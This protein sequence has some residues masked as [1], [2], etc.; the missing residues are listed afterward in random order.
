M[1][2]LPPEWMADNPRE[3]ARAT[4]DLHLPYVRTIRVRLKSDKASAKSGVVEQ[5]TT[6]AEAVVNLTT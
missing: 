2:E 3:R 5:V 6:K 1:M 4:E